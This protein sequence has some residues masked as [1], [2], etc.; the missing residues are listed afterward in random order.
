MT[1]SLSAIYSMHWSA[2][3]YYNYEHL[4]SAKRYIVDEISTTMWQISAV[5]IRKA[6][7]VSRMRKIIVRWTVPRC[8]KGNPY[9][10]PGDKLFQLKKNLSCVGNQTQNQ[11]LFGVVALPFELSR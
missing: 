9:R 4:I 7:E 2:S 1:D 3:M 5:K 11:C 10:F 8:Y 6:K